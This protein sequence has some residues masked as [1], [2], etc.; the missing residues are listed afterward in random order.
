MVAERRI[1]RQ[2]GPARVTKAGIR[3]GFMLLS[4][5][6]THKPATDL[7]YL[8]H[9]NPGNL[10]SADFGFGTAHVFYP[11]ATEDET[12]A[13]VIVDVDPVGLVRNRKNM[14][15]GNDFSLAQYVNDRPYAASSF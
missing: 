15:H 12:T 9:K 3:L 14:P 5:T 7:G 2:F 13:A 10:H 8:L 6:T 4:I 1:K 11:V